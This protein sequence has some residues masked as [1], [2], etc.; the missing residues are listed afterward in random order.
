M[1][2]VTKVCSKCKEEKDTTE[3][4]K[5]AATPDGL[6]RQCIPCKKARDSKYYKDNKE[7][8]VNHYQEQRRQRK[9]KFKEAFKTNVSCMICGEDDPV[10]L[11]FHH[12]DPSEKEFTISNMNGYCSWHTLLKEIGKCVIICRNCHAKIH[13]YGDNYYDVSSLTQR[14]ADFIDSLG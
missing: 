9:A 3:F 2:M 13:E 6:Q 10:C 11:D 12:T 8:L 7:K 5:N 1:I 4:Y 14:M